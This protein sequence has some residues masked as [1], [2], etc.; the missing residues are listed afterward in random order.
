MP[1]SPYIRN[2]RAKIGHDLLL[3]QSATVILFDEDG[4]ML[5][6]QNKET[7]VWMTVGGAIDP[8]EEPADAAVRECWEETG[9]LVRPIRLLGVF[10]GP[11]FRIVYPNGDIA[12]YV[13]I[14]FEARRISGTLRAD[15]CET[16]ALKFVSREESKSLPMAPWNE[17]MVATAFEYKDRTYFAPPTWKPPQTA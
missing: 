15:G 5:L 3:L 1:A 17:F 9:L 7:G 13:A 6:A 8:G 2:L 10:G 16:S 4:Q 14:V 11:S 12:S